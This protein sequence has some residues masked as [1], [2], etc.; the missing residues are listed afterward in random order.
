MESSRGVGEDR[1]MR[2]T[3]DKAAWSVE[4]WAAF[5]YSARVCDR[6]DVAYCQRMS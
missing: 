1:S 6:I 3:R 5:G 4:M 2:I